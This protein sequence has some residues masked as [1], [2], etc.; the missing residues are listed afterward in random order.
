MKEMKE[1]LEEE[2]QAGGAPCQ[3]AKSSLHLLIEAAV[4]F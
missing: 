1:M 4:M 3:L 2:K